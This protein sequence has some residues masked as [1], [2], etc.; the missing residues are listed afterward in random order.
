MDLDSAAEERISRWSGPRR[1]FNVGYGIKGQAD[2]AIVRDFA[3]CR[4][5]PANSF[6]FKDWSDFTTS[7]N[8]FSAPAATDQTIGAGDAVTTTFQLTK[9][10]SSGGVT[11]TRNLLKPVAGTVV[12]AV[13]GTPVASAG[14]WSV[15]TT[16]GIITFTSAPALAAAITAGCEFDCAVRFGTDIDAQFPMLLENFSAGQVPDIPLIEDKD[17]AVGWDEY[18][19][20]GAQVVNPMTANISITELQGRAV[21]VNP[22]GAGLSIT[23]PPIASVASGGPIFFLANLNNTNAVTVKDAAAATVLTLAALSTAELYVGSDSFGA[24][25]WLAG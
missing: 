7:S 11:R 5:G 24:K 18:F 19:Y 14:N 9:T 16:T 12:V 2:L 21:S 8:G 3:I 23:L 25:V 17:P 15:N 20:G 1:T 6:R 4:D 13:N 22:T 10:Y